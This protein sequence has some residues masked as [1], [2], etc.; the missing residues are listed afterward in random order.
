MADYLVT[1]T[2]LTSVANA[3]RTKGGTSATLSFPTG[4]VSAINDISS[5]KQL[6]MGYFTPTADV[7]SGDYTIV[8]VAT[9]G[10][11][12]D[13]FIV[14]KHTIGSTSGYLDY[15]MTFVYD[16]ADSTATYKPDHWRLFKA[17]SSSGSGPKVGTGLSTSDTGYVGIVSDNVVYRATSS[18]KLK[19]STRYDW[20]A[21]GE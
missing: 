19:A 16:G 5:G 3:I 10:F 4:F 14:H 6:K 8:S 11:T 2:E 13:V 20:I 17:S 21:V 9:L 18:Y 12:P 15:T 7:S 1:D